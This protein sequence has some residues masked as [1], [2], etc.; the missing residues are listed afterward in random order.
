MIAPAPLLLPAMALALVAAWK[1]HTTGSIPD[2]LTLPALA[3][4]PFAHGL[5]ARGA[6]APVE[7]ALL[8]AAAAVAGAMIAAAA[9]LVLFR[10]SALG[11]GDVKLFAALGAMAQIERGLAIEIYAFAIAAL[12]AP[13]QL[14]HEGKLLSTLRGAAALAWNVVAPAARRTTVDARAMSWLRLG[15][16][17]YLGVAATFFLEP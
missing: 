3:I 6:G 7:G 10:R 8:E 17:V 15:P 16:S 14:A 4:A 1:D 13:A 5:M 9:P 12:W 2:A 11:G